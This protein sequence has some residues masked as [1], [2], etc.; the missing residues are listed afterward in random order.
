MPT[1]PAL[2]SPITANHQKL[3]GIKSMTKKATLTIEL[4]PESQPINNQQ[5]KKE[6]T[7]TLT[8]DWLLKI[9]N[10]KIEE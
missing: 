9:Q 2:Y 10:I 5:I 6:I 7:K 8:C 1:K 3:G 4:V